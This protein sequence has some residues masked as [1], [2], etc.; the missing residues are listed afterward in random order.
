M[1]LVIEKGIPLLAKSTGKATSAIGDAVRKLEVGDSFLIPAEDKT[2]KHRAIHAYFKAE[3]K[4][5]K[6][7][8]TRQVDGGIRVWRTA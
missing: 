3:V 6:K 4:R 2:P 7:F 8:A 1:S 5:G